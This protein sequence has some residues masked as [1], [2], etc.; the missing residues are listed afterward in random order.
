MDAETTDI[1]KNTET[2]DIPESEIPEWLKDKVKEM[3]RFAV[4]NGGEREEGIGNETGFFHVHLIIPKSVPISGTFSADWQQILSHITSL[5]GHTQ[6]LATLDVSKRSIFYPL[7][8]EPRFVHPKQP[9]PLNQLG[10][11]FEGLTENITIDLSKLF[12]PEDIERYRANIVPATTGGNQPKEG[13]L[14][15]LELNKRRWDAGTVHVSDLENRE[16]LRYAGVLYF[17]KQPDGD[18][19]WFA[20]Y[21]A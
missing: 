12:S 14:S 18:F 4:Q 5:L 6:E 9:T 17:Y 15:Y 11:E 3:M 19:R 7:D 16:N 13:I 21:I 20:R 8:G 2:G 1:S 10:T